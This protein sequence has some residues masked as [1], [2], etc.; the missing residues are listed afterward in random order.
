MPT[1]AR[2]RG[3]F[4]DMLYLKGVFKA[5]GA[6]QLFHQSEELDASHGEVGILISVVE[7][8]NAVRNCRP[9]ARDE[10][11]SALKNITCSPHRPRYEKFAEAVEL[12]RKRGRL[13]IGGEIVVKCCVRID[14]AAAPTVV[15]NN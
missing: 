3:W 4:Y 15:V 9:I 13:I 2:G 14:R 11:G 6:T 5:A 10:V 8:L 7:L 1:P 12:E